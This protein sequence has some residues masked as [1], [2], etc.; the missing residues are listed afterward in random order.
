MD[1]QKFFEQMHAKERLEKIKRFSQLNPLLPKGAIVMA[2]SSLAEQF[3][4][5]ELTL[6][7]QRRSINDPMIINRG[8]GGDVIDNLSMNLDTLI[9]ELAPSKLFINIGSND[10][11]RLDYQE[12]ILMLKYDTL[13]SQIKSQLPHLELYILSYYPVNPN[14]ASD[15]PVDIKATMFATRTNE[16][17]ASANQQLQLLAKKHNATYIDVHRCL[18]NSAGQLDEKL[19]IEGIHLWPEAY[20]C[21]YEVLKPYFY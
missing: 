21:V 15:I 1:M 16:A 20:V 7:D 10:I 6:A 19:T 17:I 3:P 2:G 13:L 14:V 4:I 18:L 5:Y 8:I 11:G 12:E 9:I